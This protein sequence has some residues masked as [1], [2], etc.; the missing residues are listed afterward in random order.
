M[1][2]CAAAAVDDERVAKDEVDHAVFRSGVAN[3]ASIW[4]R[5]L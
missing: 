4:R 5:V 2:R 3:S 1:E